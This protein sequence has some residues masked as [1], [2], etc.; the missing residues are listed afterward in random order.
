MN[1]DWVTVLAVAASVATIASTLLAVA[2]TERF[3]AKSAE[4]TKLQRVRNTSIWTSISLTLQC[5]ET[6]EDA[7][8]IDP[9]VEPHRISQK[10]ASARR[11]VVAQYL[12][13]L[14]EAA[15]DEPEFSSTTVELWKRQGRLE[16]T[17]RVNEAM[18]LV[19]T[20]A[21]RPSNQL[22]ATEEAPFL[23]GAGAP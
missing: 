8:K 15:L 20:H 19:P 10:I 5:F 22:E 1:A 2:Q 11:C 6:L 16:N 21:F 9:V 12:H 3:R 4:L 14:G 18:K 17:W 7:R 23:P 13:L